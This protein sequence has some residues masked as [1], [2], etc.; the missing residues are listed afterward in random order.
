[1]IN[2]GGNDKE[3]ITSCPACFF[4]LDGLT[5]AQQLERIGKIPELKDLIGMTVATRDGDAGSLHSYFLLDVPTTDVWRW[6]LLQWR[7]IQL[8]NSDSKVED[9]SRVMRL[10][11]AW[12]ALGDGTLHSRSHI[13]ENDH[14]GKRLSF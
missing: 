8:Y 4:E 11:G 2:N 9:P 5:K 3:S 10:P 6:R 1:M 12:Y 14:T 13:V 7:L